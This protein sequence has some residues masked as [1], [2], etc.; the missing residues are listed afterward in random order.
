VYVGRYGGPGK[1]VVGA[2][3]YGFNTG[4]TG[5]SV[6]G[7]YTS[8]TPPAATLGALAR[9]LAWKL[10]RHGLDPLGTASMTCGAAQ[11]YAAGQVVS[12][13]VV[14]G[15]RDVNYTACPGD[16]LYAKLGDVRSAAA[17]QIA[18]AG[19]APGPYG[20]TLT[21]S[22]GQV[23]AGTPVTF[24]GTVA[25]AT[26]APASGKVVVQKRLAPDGSWGDWRTVT[27]NATG[28]YS[29][30]VAMTSAPRDWQFRARMPGDGGANL[31]GTSAVCALSVCAPKPW[32]VSLRLS[33]GRVAAGTPVTFA[34]TVKSANG[35][36]A[37]GKVA[38]QRRR[39][40]DG[41]WADWR[42]VTPDATGAYSVTVAMTSA[43][44]SWKFRARVPGDGAFNL[45]GTSP[46]KLLDVVIPRPYAVTLSLSAANAAAGTSVT[47]KGAVKTADG[48]PASGTV[49]LQK[50][51]AP[52]GV[53][54]DWRT[55]ALSSIGAYRVAVTMTSAPR[56]WQIRARMPGDGAVNLA[57]T[58]PARELRVTP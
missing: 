7:T 33:G 43:P 42:S 27:L 17:R 9:L 36:P 15:H 50:R 52:D 1:G 34:G 55:T 40:P 56:T 44:R 8:E 14:S 3:A 51:L 48:V 54:L 2:Q 30:T 39:V 53:W 19:V 18:L 11:K 10:E 37:S 46:I 26:G 58:S 16:A 6:M 41:A 20:A 35:G 45:A 24:K 29:V 13:P 25:T 22:A 23:L 47:F 5:I 4:S 21:V 28:A 12:L 38:V 49:T 31:A 57:G 32:V